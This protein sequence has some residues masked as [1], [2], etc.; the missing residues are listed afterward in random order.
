MSASAPSAKLPV[1][2]PRWRTW[3]LPGAIVLLL[4]ALAVSRAMTASM[5]NVRPYD[6][7]SLQPMGLRALHQAFRAMGYTV[8]DRRGAFFAPPRDGDLLLTWPGA[9]SWSNREVLALR[10]WV[11]RGGTAVVVANQSDYQWSFE[12]WGVDVSPHYNLYLNSELVQ[13]Q[14]LLPESPASMA[15]AYSPIHFDFGGNIVPA[16][17]VERTGWRATAGVE[18]VGNGA[19]WYLTDAHN[20]TNANLADPNQTA[21]LAAILRLVPDGGTIV[22]DAYH[23]YGPEVPEGEP[24][25][26]QTIQDWLY[27]DPLGQA[28]LFA[29]IVGVLGWVMAGRRLGPPLRSVKELKRREGAEYVRA[30][31]GLKRRAHAGEE[32][33]ARQRLRLKNSLGRPRHIAAALDDG[34]FITAL[35]AAGDLDSASIEQ[36]EALLVRLR[37]AR[38]EKALVTASAAV[39][40]FLG[41]AGQ[42]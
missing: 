24:S 27:R 25:P 40:E 32:I 28:V 12:P 23:L 42:L 33:A 14:P 39:D 30:L 7:D 13:A 29:L 6:F 16:T 41:G 8:I 35:R 21:I 15:S 3:I 18:T 2:T 4:I 34:A 36:A 11:E 5:N 10:R 31:A 1:A 20:L 38:D 22:F 37:D 9:E 26:A 19:I 17:M